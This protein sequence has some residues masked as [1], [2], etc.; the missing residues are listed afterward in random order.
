[1]LNLCH[2]FHGPRF[3]WLGW[4]GLEVLAIENERVRVVIW[5]EHGADI[6]EF[7]NK[8][9]DLDVLWKNPRVWPLRARPLGLPHASRS[10][11]YDVFHG[12]WFVSA[13]NGFFPSD[14]P[15]AGGAPIGCHGEM[16]SL[17]WE[18]AV[19]KCDADEVL[20][21]ASGRSVR[22][23]LRLE[24]LWKLVSGSAVLECRE[25]L[26]NDS[27]SRLP[28]A[29]QHHPAFGGPL[30]C[31]AQVLTCARTVSVP[32]SSRPELS[33]LRPEYR[34][35]WPYVPETSGIGRRDCSQAPAKG[36]PIEHVVHLHD[37]PYG[38]A[39]VWNESMQ[40]GFG[41]KWEKDIFPYCW[42]WACGQGSSSYPLWGDCHTL[43][44]QPSTSP[45]L[46]FAHLV[47]RDEVTWVAP[48]GFIG[49]CIQAGFIRAP[50][51]SF[52]APPE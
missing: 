38:W 7:R 21:R 33:Q 44:L 1:M 32:P 8:A 4:N 36:S 18:V 27:G 45:L 37:F 9:T 34:G 23:P 6:I 30:I 17:S 43:T 31:G 42:L 11:F 12:G 15:A 25:E 40:L 29:W 47:E 3:Q 28:V 50:D 16:H 26:Y 20:V 5:P 49:S 48:R 39:A 19:V 41:L 52:A 24:R 10:E 13:P 2:C 14:W 46:P 51:E 35:P 22:T